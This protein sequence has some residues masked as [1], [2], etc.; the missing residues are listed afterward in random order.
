MLFRSRVQ[1]VR[2][3]PSA[4]KSFLAKLAADSIIFGMVAGVLIAIQV[5]LKVATGF[6]IYECFGI[7]GRG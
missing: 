6:D 4:S 3:Q 5:L 7:R 1:V 2:R